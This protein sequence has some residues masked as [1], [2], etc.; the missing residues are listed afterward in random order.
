MLPN[1]VHWFGLIM[2]QDPLKFYMLPNL[3]HWFGLKHYKGVSR[4]KSS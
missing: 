2:T 1:L 3:V 4:R